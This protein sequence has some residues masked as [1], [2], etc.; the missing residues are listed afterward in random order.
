L[1]FLF[2]GSFEQTK[3]SGGLAVESL[4]SNA[5]NAIQRCV[6]AGSVRM[7]RRRDCTPEFGRRRSQ[8]KA[9]HYEDHCPSVSQNRSQSAGGVGQCDEIRF[10]LN[11][12]CRKT[13]FAK[14]VSA[15]ARPAEN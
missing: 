5:Q 7:R 9:S 15:S 6:Y 10:S 8:E 1:G 3:F 4:E 12:I 11:E 14:E 2:C 13:L